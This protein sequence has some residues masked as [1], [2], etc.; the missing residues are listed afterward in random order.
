[1]HLPQ[2]HSPSF[3]FEKTLQEEEK[4]TLV[5]TKIHLKKSL[6]PL[7]ESLVSILLWVQ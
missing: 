7:K 1:M 5:S 2:P 3:T 6:E 4:N